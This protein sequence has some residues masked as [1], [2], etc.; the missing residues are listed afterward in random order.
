MQ[1]K[2]KKTKGKEFEEKGVLFLKQNGFKI[3]KRN[4]QTKFGEI[5]IICKKEN[6]IYFIEVKG[7]CDKNYIPEIKLNYKKR[8]ALKRACIEYLSKNSIPLNSEFRF[9]LLSFINNKISF[10]EIEKL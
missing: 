1:T 10:L 9:Y 6:V 8:K 7:S 4:F 3:I 5:D 2:N